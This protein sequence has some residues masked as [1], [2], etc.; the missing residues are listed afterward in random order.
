MPELPE[1]ETVRRELEPHVT[2]NTISSAKILSPSLRSPLPQDMSE[3]LTD[4]NIV[5]IT[6][7]AKYLLFMIDCGLTMVVHLGMTGRLSIVTKSYIPVKH[8][9]VILFLNEK[10]LVYNDP[11]RF[12]LI[13]LTKTD[14]INCHRLFAH[15][16]LEPLTKN[17]TENYLQAK[18][19]KRKTPIKV[20]IM[21]NVVIV[22]VGN[23]Y[24]S[25]S[26]FLAAIS[27]LRGANDLSLVELKKLVAAIKQVLQE[28]IESGGSSIR[29]FVSIDNNKGYFQHNFAV[30]GK[31]GNDCRRCG[32]AISKIYQGGRATF[33]CAGCQV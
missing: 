9:H 5:S 17:F 8:D 27:P 19:Q 3:L 12:G 30:Y 6:R 24:A 7:R 13:E 10:A 2:G 16:G 33:F 32:G 21:D 31:A 18:L 29:D 4:K 15:L 26:L 1:V 23:I 20:A 25:E 28:A 11:R 22:G 14:E